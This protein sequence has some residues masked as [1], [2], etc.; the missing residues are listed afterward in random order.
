M[1]SSTFAVASTSIWMG[2]V[3]WFLGN[4]HINI[5][6]FL[7]GISTCAYNKIY[8]SDIVKQQFH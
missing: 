6:Y 2:Y 8:V 3:L 1:N 4:I 7:I 5:L